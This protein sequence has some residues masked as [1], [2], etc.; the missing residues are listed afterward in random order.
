MMYVIQTKAGCELSAGDLLKRKGFNIKVPE[1]LM[2]IRRGGMWKLEKHLIFTRYIFLDID[3]VKPEAYYRIKN[4]DGV[5]NFIGG[6]NPQ[7]MHEHEIGYINWL[8][9]NGKPIEPSRIRV[10]I[11]ND[12]MILSGILKKF[13]TEINVR[14]RRAKIKIPICGV[15]KNVTLPIEII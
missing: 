5:I 13:A 6:G 2:Y 11:D 7:L 3:D 12:I 14:Q 8:W 15:Y 10:T 1:K 9:N 4:S